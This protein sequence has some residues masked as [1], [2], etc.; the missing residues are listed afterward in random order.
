MQDLP[1]LVGGELRIDR[2]LV[3]A[4]LGEGGMADVWLCRM[5]GAR[6]FSKRVVIKTIK[7]TCEGEQYESMFVDEATIGARLEHPNIPRVTEFSQTQSG[8]LFLV[9]EYVE[10]PSVQQVIAAQRA[11]GHHD[12]RLATK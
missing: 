9:Q 4:K 3:E 1:E 8:H 10:G 11:V 7:S 2:Y 5:P 6:G 12:L